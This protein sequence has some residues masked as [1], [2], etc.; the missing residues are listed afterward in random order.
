M[1]F[2]CD[3]QCEPSR[4]ESKEVSRKRLFIF[5][6]S[7]FTIQTTQLQF[8]RSIIFIAEEMNVK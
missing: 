7:I 2:S 6:S 4:A 1:H 3:L 5:S 8:D